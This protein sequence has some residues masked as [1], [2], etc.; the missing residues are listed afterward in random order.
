MSKHS[1]R[2]GASGRP[3]A[4][5]SASSAR[6][7]ALWSDGALELVARERLARVL[8]DRVHQLALGAALRHAHPHLAA[9]RCSARNSS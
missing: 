7:R 8:R 3:S 4:S 9:P 6:A 5:C 1:M 2:S